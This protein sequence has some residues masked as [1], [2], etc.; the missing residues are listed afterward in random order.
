VVADT[1]PAV[2]DVLMCYIHPDVADDTP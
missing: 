1:P 2:A